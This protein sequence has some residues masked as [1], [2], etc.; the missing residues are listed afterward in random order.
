MTGANVHEPKGADTAAVDTVYHSDGAG[1]GTWKAVDATYGE[2]YISG[3]ATATTIS[4]SATYYQVTAGWV[5]GLV[6][7]VTFTTDHMVI[8]EDGIYDLACDISMAGQTGETFQ[9]E[10]H[11]DTGGG[12]AAIGKGAIQHKTSNNDVISLGCKALYSLN[13]GDKVALFV[14]NTGATGNPTIAYADV[15]I[16]KLLSE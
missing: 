14:Q 7:N 8:T 11:V 2:M 1:S 4:A 10:F 6:N 5:T 13:S 16:H 12:Y 9:F 15:H 3:N